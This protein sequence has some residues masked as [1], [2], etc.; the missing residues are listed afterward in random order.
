M[1][2]IADHLRGA[3]LLTAQGLTPSNK[4]QGYALRRLIRRAVLKALDLGIAQD[5][6]SEIIPIIAKNYA[7][8]PDSILTHRESA[9]AVI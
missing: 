8:L 9:I 6:I 4:Q 1:R 2:I 3:Y 7:D 5:F